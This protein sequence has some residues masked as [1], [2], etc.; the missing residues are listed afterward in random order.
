MAVF[1]GQKKLSIFCP[2]WTIL[3]TQSIMVYE[4]KKI[5]KNTIPYIQKYP[6]YILIGYIVS[7]LSKMSK[8]WTTF[9]LLEKKVVA[10]AGLGFNKKFFDQLVSYGFNILKT[11]D[12]PDHHQYSVEDV[13]TLLDQANALD[14]HLITTEKDHIRVPN[15]FKKNID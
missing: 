7:F 2:F 6:K 12:Y 15:E 3:K 8:K 4:F 10:F 9:F 11:I 13:Y 14:A 1:F 5:E